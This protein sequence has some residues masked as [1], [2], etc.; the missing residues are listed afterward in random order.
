[1]PA[2]EVPA[3]YDT[4]KYSWDTYRGATTHSTSARRWVRHCRRV[5]NSSHDQFKVAVDHQ[6]YGLHFYLDY[7][8]FSIDPVTMSFNPEQFREL[9]V[10]VLKYLEPEI[11]Y[12]DTAV[13]LLMLTAATESNL[14]QYLRQVRGP[15]RGVFQ[16]EPRTEQDIWNNYLVYNEM[17]KNKI[18]GLLFIYNHADKGFP[19]MIGNLPYQIAMARV[20]YWRVPHPLPNSNPVALATYWKQHYNTHLGAGTINKAKEK[21]KEYTR[22]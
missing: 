11:P 10:N 17:L 4:K 15:A 3:N 9:I 7:D 21:Y 12:S 22:G 16:M 6:R 18:E 19:D 5:D 14:G 2:Q 1:L 13:E 20:Y 8:H